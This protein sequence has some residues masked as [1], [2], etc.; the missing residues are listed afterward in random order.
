MLVLA[1]ESRGLSQGDFATELDVAQAY[2]SRVESG[3]QN[4]SEDMLEKA[5]EKL[6][7][8]VNFFYQSDNVWG[9]G[10]PCNY[11]R[12]RDSLLMRDWYKLT[13]KL[14]ILRLHIT[15]LLRAVQI[16]SQFEFKLYDVDEDGGPERIAKLV[17]RDWAIK[18]GPV[19]NLISAIE[20]AGGIVFKTPFGT[21]KLDAIS[22]WLPG[23]PPIFLVNSEVSGDRLR[24]TLAH[25]V[26]HMILH[27]KFLSEDAEREADRFASEF[28]MPAADIGHQLNS[29]TVKKAA[30][31]LKPYWKVSIAA[32]LFRA[33]ELRK[34]TGQQYV[35]QQKL[36]SYYGYRKHEPVLIPQEEP[37]VLPKVLDLFLNEQKHSS[38]ELSSMLA[39]HEEEFKD[40]YFPG[41]LRLLSG[42]RIALKRSAVG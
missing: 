1:R 38:E 28:L 2:V 26:G 15:R 20:R 37:V 12:K 9:V 6:R 13:A 19:S 16:E 35:N 17:R 21:E 32:L 30:T 27:T 18:P 14:N 24:F 29:L 39:I 23:E 36:I 3:L 34:I 25:E 4:I 22:Q 7:Y 40:M 33:K 5:A 42:G 41:Q 31:N 8:P 10:S 11:H